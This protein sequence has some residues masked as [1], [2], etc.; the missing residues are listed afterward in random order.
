MRIR[1]GVITSNKMAKTLVVQVD[2]YKMHPKYHKRY[3][4]SKKFYAHTEETQKY[5]IGQMIEIVETKPM[6]KLKRW[7]VLAEVNS[8]VNA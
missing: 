8:A 3:K 5:E 6:S 1:K 4:S 2:T 7:L